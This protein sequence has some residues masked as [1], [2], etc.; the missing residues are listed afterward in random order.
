[1]VSGTTEVWFGYEVT[2]GADYVAGTD[3]G[4]AVAG[5]GD[6]IS[7]D[8]SVWESMSQAYALNYN[9]NLQAWVQS[10]DGVNTPLQ[11][12]SDNGVLRSST[13]NAKL[14]RGAI[15]T[16]SNVQFSN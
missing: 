11:P 12:I 3:A 15:Q 16:S 14:T 7:L 10:V 13:A 8:G 5:Y 4:P 9:W 2:H 1:M 6:M